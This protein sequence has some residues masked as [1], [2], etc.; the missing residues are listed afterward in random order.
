[1]NLTVLAA[2]L[3]LA[4]AVPSG[5]QEPRA[6][7]E[8][9]AS[10]LEAAVS[11]VSVPTPAFLGSAPRRA[12]RI[13][14][15]GVVIVLPSRVLPGHAVP[16]PRTVPSLLGPAPTPQGPVLAAQGRRD[17]ERAL[18][19]LRASLQREAE[20]SQRVSIM[21]LRGSD[22]ATLEQEARQRLAAAA[23]ARAEAQHALM[24]AMQSAAQPPRTLEP[25]PMG[26][27]PPPILPQAFRPGLDRRLG[28]TPEEAVRRVREALV[29]ALLGEPELGALLPPGESVSAAIDFVALGRNGPPQRTLV[30]RVQV[31]DLRV[32]AEGQLGREALASRVMVNEY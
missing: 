5:A 12:Y 22:L 16:A 28:R 3:L 19:E 13:P 8:A 10:R 32:M 17:I 23:R 2:A 25:E 14:G 31:R 11:Q 7:L 9:L 20:A 15:V 4:A 21:P 18:L 29:Q 26:T 1:V 30:V 27:A 6:G 24:V